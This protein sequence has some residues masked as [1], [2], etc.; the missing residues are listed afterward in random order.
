MSTQVLSRTIERK[1]KEKS[2]RLR[3]GYV[4][5]RVTRYQLLKKSY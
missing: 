1:K 4:S 2:L 3:W 5:D